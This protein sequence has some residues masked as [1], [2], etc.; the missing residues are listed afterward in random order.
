MY[1]RPVGA[2]GVDA[3][4][5]ASG[6]QHTEYAFSYAYPGTSATRRLGRRYRGRGRGWLVSRDRRRQVLFSLNAND[7]IILTSAQLHDMETTQMGC[8]VT[9]INGYR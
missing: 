2:M 1:S 4:P 5:P 8:D 7:G 3:K 6:P 9:S